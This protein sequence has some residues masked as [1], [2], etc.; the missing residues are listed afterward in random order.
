M[1]S[2]CRRIAPFAALLVVMLRGGTVYAQSS[3]PLPSLPPPAPAAPLPALPPGPP[4]ET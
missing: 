3:A 4:A 2:F 1:L